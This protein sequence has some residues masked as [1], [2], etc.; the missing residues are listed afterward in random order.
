MQLS[1]IRD[2]S[3]RIYLDRQ[4]VQIGVAIGG[5]LLAVV[6][7]WNKF[8]DQS[9]RSL[10]I[11]TYNAL[12]DANTHSD[13]Y[14]HIQPS[15]LQWESRQEALIAHITSFQSDII[16]LQEIEPAFYQRLLQRLE[17]RGYDGLYVRKLSNRPDG[18]A[19]FY[20]SK[21]LK[22]TNEEILYFARSSEEGGMWRPA[23]IIQFEL[24]GKRCGLINLHLA[25][26]AQ[27]EVAAAQ[28]NQLLEEIIKPRSTVESWILCGDFNSTPESSA[29]ELLRRSGF[30]YADEGAEQITC[31]LPHFAGKIDYIFYSTNRLKATA[32]RIAEVSFGTPLPS[33]TEP[34][35]HLAVT[36]RISVK[37]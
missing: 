11:T 23:Q 28:L 5:T 30:R 4:P 15:I 10:K 14:A 9:L 29:I 24:G 22:V 20:K 17:S 26:D 19:L 2:F 12:A 27:G 1:D 16:C 18:L 6:F 13:W 3:K 35:D 25:W 31:S 36:A 32:T 34:S 21:S 37:N 33:P 7:V 8:R